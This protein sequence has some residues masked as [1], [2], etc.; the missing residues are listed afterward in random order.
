MTHAAAIVCVS[1]IISYQKTNIFFKRFSRKSCP[2]HVSVFKLSIFTIANP[3]RPRKAQIMGLFDYM[4][5]EITSE[6]EMIF[7]I[8]SVLKI[9]LMKGI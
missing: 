8:I 6:A 4:H 3:R 1:S 7:F 5:H 9:C 2:R